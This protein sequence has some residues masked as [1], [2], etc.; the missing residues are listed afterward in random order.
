MPPHAASDAAAPTKGRPGLT[1]LA[2]LAGLFITLLDVTV[3]NVAL[4]TIR[5]DLDT[6]FT[7]LEWI[8]NAYLLAL[9]V[10][11]VTAGRL[12]DIHG[13]RRIY[14][15]G[16]VTFLAGS[17]ICGLAGDITVLHAGRVVQGIG[18][19]VVI[20]LTLAIIYT[21]FDGPLRA[22]GIML[23]GA[24]GGLATALGPLIGGFLVQHIG[25]ES[26]FLVNLPIGAVVIAATLM[27]VEDKRRPENEPRPPMDVLGLLSISIA[28]FCLNLALVNGHG[29]GWTSGRVLGLLAAA[30][31]MLVAFLVVEARSASPIMDLSWFRRPSFGGS[32]VAGFL[33]G[34][35]MFSIIFY[36]SIYLQ[37]G[38][39]LSAQ[40]TGVR[41]LPLTLMLI[42]GAPLGGRL[43]AKSG[44]RVAL[45]ATLALMAVGI[46][47]FTLIDPDGDA[48]SWV[49]LL[50]GMLVCG[51][52]TGVAMPIVSEL[53]V[54]TAPQNQVGVASSVG[55]ML[56]QVGNAM[57]VAIM[58]TLMSIQ[59]NQAEDEVTGL[60]KAGTLTP[61]A[62]RHIGGRAVAHALQHAAWYG[63]AVTLL[64]ALLV[65]RF[66]SSRPP[67]AEPPAQPK[68]DVRLPA[69]TQR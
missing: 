4:P 47:L 11:I 67:A 20:P 5:D 25:W 34:A 9:G 45:G 69:Y 50:P 15:L 14:V 40:A 26:I 42:V 8:A 6:S 65:F 63:A 16:V 46:A 38:L 61:D 59:I 32:A 64:A 51:L 39:H 41:L 31:V 43:V 2:A 12:G 24:V 30:V 55:T 53:T 22:R 28:L 66:V 37:N 44:P 10:F 68:D 19:A 58:G 1:M 57:G 18:G 48:G 54:S 52:A 62:A 56:R 7:D 3:V 35:G 36:L 33:L 13:H 27:A 17:L 29:W 23:W 21:N 60:R 49:R